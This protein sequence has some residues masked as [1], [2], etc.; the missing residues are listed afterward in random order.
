MI[1]CHGKKLRKKFKP[2]ELNRHRLQRVCHG[3]QRLGVPGQKQ[4]PMAIRRTP[5]TIPKRVAVSR[6]WAHQGRQAKMAVMTKK[7]PVPRHKFQ[8]TNSNRLPLLPGLALRGKT[9]RKEFPP[10]EL[11]CHRLPCV[12]QLNKCLGAK[13]KKQAPT[14]NS[15]N[16]IHNSENNSNESN[17]NTSRTASKNGG[18]DKKAAHP[19]WK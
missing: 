8:I 17:V 15:K 6:I 18:N 14:G 12:C 11:N 7:F 5:S 4:A 9:L 1:R 10:W 16:P 19:K 3:N 2:W 13:R